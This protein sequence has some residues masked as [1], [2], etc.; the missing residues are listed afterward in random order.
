[1][2]EKILQNKTVQLVP[3]REDHERA[4]LLAAADGE[5]WNL[6]VTSVP[7]A[8]EVKN[9]IKTALREQSA[10][11]SIPFVV[12]Y[13]P[14]GKLIGCTRYCNI[15]LEHAR[16]EIGYTWYAKSFQKTS[17]NTECKLLLLENAFEALNCKCVQFKTHHENYASQKAI[18][19][20]GA[21][22]DGILRNDRLQADGSSRHTYVYSILS[23]EW[24]D[25][26]KNLQ[27][28]LQAYGSDTTQ[29]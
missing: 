27:Q 8:T 15:A 5:L 1:M 12:E 25:I 28:K 19:R 9:Y 23:S 24:Q 6:K 29:R 18:E 2:A 7:D 22:L 14:S 20:L 3:L 26:K 11:L 16:L 13:L 21:K 4:L 10:G 17:V